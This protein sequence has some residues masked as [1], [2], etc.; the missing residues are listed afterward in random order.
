MGG[1]FLQAQELVA[2][3]TSNSYQSLVTSE[4]LSALGRLSTASAREQE[5]VL[6]A[7]LDVFH[8]LPW[9]PPSRSDV[10]ALH[11]ETQYGAWVL[12]HGYNV[13]HFT[14]LVNSHKVPDLDTIEKTAAALAA[15]GVPMKPDIEGA[16]GS[17]LRQTATN[18]VKIACSMS[19]GG[20]SI[21]HSCPAVW[22]AVGRGQRGTERGQGRKG[23]PRV[24]LVSSP[25]TRVHILP[26]GLWASE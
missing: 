15:A 9:Q 16:V 19:E 12:V 20:A 3:A 14:A 26:C 23:R 1:R 13:N 21:C 6:L 5:D 22:H 2:S 25:L 4:L 8:S 17:N 24:R 7:T 10:E 18:A 11:K